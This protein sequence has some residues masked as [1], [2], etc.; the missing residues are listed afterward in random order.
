MI[1]LPPEMKTLSECM[2]AAGIPI[3]QL[4]TASGLDKRTVKAIVDGNYVPDALQ[5]E[6]LARAAGV[7]KEEISWDHAV[8]V[9]HMRGNGPQF[10]RST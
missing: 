1:T 3:G 8:S 9:Q 4:V 10:G 5:R 2:E 6:R 7:S